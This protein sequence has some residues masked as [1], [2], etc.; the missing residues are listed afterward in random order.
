MIA[1]ASSGEIALSSERGVAA[2]LTCC[3]CCWVSKIACATNGEIVFCSLT[4]PAKLAN[5]CCNG[6]IRLNGFLFGFIFNKF[7]RFNLFFFSVLALKP[8]PSAS[9]RVIDTEPSG[10]TRPYEPTTVPFLRRSSSL[11][12]TFPESG[13]SIS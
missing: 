13:S 12:W 1:V 8:R 4:V 6:L 7:P 2:L 5:N 11:N 10:W 3:C 9:Y